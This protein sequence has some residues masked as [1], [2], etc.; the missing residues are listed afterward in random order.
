MNLIDKQNSLVIDVTYRCNAKCHY[1]KWG[2][3]ETPG[4]VNQSKKSVF[5]SKE[6]L[7]HLNTQR[8]VLS[9]GEPLLHK[10]LEEIILYY[11]QSGVESILIITNGLLLSME[12]L[13]NLV[14]SGLTGVVFSIDSFEQKTAH[15]TRAYNVKQLKKIKQN[16]ISACNLKKESKF[17]IGINIVISTENISNRHLEK[18]I[19]FTNNYPL[20]WIK[21]QPIFDDGYVGSNAP[22]L[23][24]NSLHAELIR[25]TGNNILDIIK[26]ESNPI[27]FWESLAEVLDGNKL[28]GKSCGLDTRQAVA[29]NGQIKICSWIDYPSY[30]ITKQSIQETQKEFAK[31]K[32]QCKT[33]TFCYCLQNLS[34][35]WE[36][37]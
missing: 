25:I 32:S 24:L 17:E 12:R 10:N 35:K 11:Q 19:E 7:R 13:T 21:F 3:Q 28:K 8:I 36:T 2:N 30:D 5:I 34:H 6:T 22:H 18:F 9:G 4:R 16:F 27:S 1:C 31:V 33:E 37:E 23:L 14:S 15:A 26:T 29:Q 20:D